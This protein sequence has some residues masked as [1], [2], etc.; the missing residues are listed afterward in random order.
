VGLLCPVLWFL[1]LTSLSVLDRI[2]VLDWP[3][4][5]VLLHHLSGLLV[6][7]LLLVL[8]AGLRD[9]LVGAV[10]EHVGG[11]SKSDED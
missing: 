6:L 7:F 3:V 5:L 10:A 9:S 2:G 1:V 11:L 8:V 4:G